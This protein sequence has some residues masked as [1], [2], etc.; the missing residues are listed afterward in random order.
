[1]NMK[2][3]LSLLLAALMV[4]S[5]G[6]AVADVADT[7]I[8]QEEFSNYI[9]LLTD[10]GTI[11]VQ[12]PAATKE[13]KAYKIFDAVFDAND[14][15]KVAYTIRSDSQWYNDLKDENYFTFTQVEGTEVY[16][17]TANVGLNA[18]ELA[19]YLKTKVD[20]KTADAELTKDPDT[21][22]VSTS[23]LPYGY[24]F[25]TSTLGSLCALDTT[26]PN[27]V[28]YEKND[29]PKIEKKIVEGSEEVDYNNAAIGDTVH[30]KIT[31]KVPAME[32]YTTYTFKV[33]DN[34]SKGLTFQENTLVVKIGDTK[35]V[36]DSDYTMTTSKIDEGTQIVIDF[37][38]FIQHK[39][40]LDQAITITYDAV[41]NH[42]AVI[43]VAGNPNKVKLEYSNNPA[44]S[45]QGEGKPSTEETNWDEVIT[46]VTEIILNKV[47]EDNDPLAGATFK[48]TGTKL[49]TVI[50]TTGKSIT[51][52]DSQTTITT[53]TTTIVKGEDVKY[54]ATTGPDGKLTFSGL[55]AGDY[56][57]TEITAPDGYN[58][59]P[60]PI[61]VTIDWT[62][63][64]TADST[65]CTWTYKWSGIDGAENN[66]SN[67][68]TVKNTKGS[69]LPSTG[70]MGTTILYAVGGVLVLA[71]FVLIVTKR[72]ASEN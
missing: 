35:L 1:M 3:W 37:T 46:Y 24:Y 15:T 17:V 56:V 32:G 27:A 45:G 36:K 72:R 68:I 63:P 38:N 60:K 9:M 30:Y 67:T 29:H 54:E 14:A 4:L 58:L 23:G 21:G 10:N 19:A 33:T 20:G 57:I 25:I 69:E 13:Y 11:T 41:V 44:Q 50:V 39:G 42:D 66:N 65:N 26:N 2:K 16:V 53:E 64:T 43:G 31:S 49:N 51:D 62:A 52:K 40:K 5:L 59:L 47:D 22:K 55:A 8:P 61:K 70:G 34:L 12:N 28:I 71:A 18:A 48:L 6:T 7:T